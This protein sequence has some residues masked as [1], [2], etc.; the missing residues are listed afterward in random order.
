M[1][2]S[3]L[4]K[5]VLWYHLCDSYDIGLFEDAAS[6]GVLSNFYSEISDLSFLCVLVVWSI[7]GRV[8]IFVWFWLCEGIETKQIM[9]QGKR[10]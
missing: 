6:W 2:P 4:S 1:S 7:V 5:S 10:V 3:F 8:L 9:R